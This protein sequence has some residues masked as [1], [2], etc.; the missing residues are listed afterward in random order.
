LSRREA[1]GLGG[2]VLAAA[3]L[4]IVLLVTSQSMADGDEAVTG[5]MAM[6]ILRGAAHPVYPYGIRYGAGAGVEAHLAAGLF[7]LFGISDVALK[8]VGLLLWLPCVVLLF[9]IVR[10]LGGARAGLVAA[11]LYA[12][13]PATA[14]WSLKVAGGHTV[15]VLLSLLALHLLERRPANRVAPAVLPLAVVAHPVTAGLAAATAG[16][17][18]HRCRGPDRWRL[19]ATLAVTSAA[20]AWL[21]WP[22]ETGVWNPAARGFDPRALAAAA[23]RLLVNLFV[24]NL[25]ARGLPEPLRLASSAT[26]LLAF[27]VAVAAFRG[28]RRWYVYTFGS[29]ATLLLV[30]PGQLVARHALAFFPLACGTIAL[31]LSPRR[32]GTAAAAGLVALGI[33][34]HGAEARSPYLYG[35]G[36]QSV[37]VDRAAARAV[38][39][40]LEAA[41]VHHVYC[42]DPMFQWNLVFESRGRIL[43]RW[44]NPEDRVPRFALEVD[45]ARRAGLPVGVVWPAAG[46]DTGAPQRFQWSLLGELPP[47]FEE[48]FP[49]AVDPG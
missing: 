39:R 22:G 8:A 33:A 40:G 46:G 24:P 43:A 5:L 34:V 26:W 21:L 36:I 3:L 49:P 37:G 29:L 10:G 1:W 48:R 25:G 9:L 16:V 41:G 15:G 18:L 45:R 17:A 19:L 28:P 23:P 12:A 32:G 2:V 35:A 6:D 30:A 14:L 44:R 42:A 4:K 11:G 7:A 13:C 38:V 27:A 47:G 20:L 31:G